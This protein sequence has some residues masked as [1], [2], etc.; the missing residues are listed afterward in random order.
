MKSYSLKSYA[1]LSPSHPPTLSLLPSTSFH[2]S[3][4][5]LMLLVGCVAT[6]KPS[7]HFFPHFVSYIVLY[8]HFIHEK[9]DTQTL[10]FDLSTLFHSSY[11]DVQSLTSS[12]ML[13]KCYTQEE[14]NDQYAK[15][16]VVCSVYT[17][18]SLYLQAQKYLFKVAVETYDLIIWFKCLTIEMWS[19]TACSF[20]LQCSER[21]KIL[22][23]LLEP[24]EYQL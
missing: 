20:S 14:G 2:A 15:C 17:C 9:W 21:N 1:S 18:R 12:L 16:T 8:T 6:W 4:T 19:K 23:A 22:S 13:L 10:V 5:C 24:L 7:L 3:T 11:V